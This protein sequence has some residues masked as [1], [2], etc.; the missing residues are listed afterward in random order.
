MVIYKDWRSESCLALYNQMCALLT[1]F[2][3]IR[4]GYN[5]YDMHARLSKHVLMAAAV[6]IH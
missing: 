6:R 5:I 1:H 2:L 4:S 3:V